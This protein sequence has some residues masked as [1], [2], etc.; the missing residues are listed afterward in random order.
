MTVF[1]KNTNYGLDSTV[2]EIQHH[3]DS[4]IA[5]NATTNALGWRGTVNVYGLCYPTINDGNRVLEAYIGT[6]TKNKEY[7]RIFVNDKITASIGFVEVGDR[8][9]SD[10]R[11]VNVDVIVTMRLDLAYNS[12]LRN[13]ELAMLQ[14]ERVL[15]SFYGIYEVESSK[16]GIEDVF[17]GYYFGDI[18]NRDIHPWL[19]FSMR[20]NLKYEDDICQ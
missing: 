9:L 2:Y 10:T 14:F 11:N 7:S 17:S 4:K 12:N 15:E 19:V 16:T 20:V 8:D 1:S 18:L 3:I 6:G 13:D 5:Y